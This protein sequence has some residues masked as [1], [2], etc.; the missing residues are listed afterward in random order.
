MLFVVVSCA[1]Q[2]KYIQYTVKRGETMKSIAQRLNMKTRDLLRL[3]PDVGRRPDPNT[4]II[5][6]QV[7]E[8]KKVD[9]EVAIVD[10]LPIETDLDTL[11]L[12]E[13]EVLTDEILRNYVIHK[14]KKGDTYYRLARIYNVKEQQIRDLNPDL[15]GNILPEGE[16]IKIKLIAPK[17]VEYLNYEDEIDPRASVRLAMLLPFRATAYDS[18]PA[19]DIFSTS[20][21]AN[22][23]T[24]LYL[25]ASLAI[26]SLKKQG[27]NINVD[28]FDTGSKNTK[29]DSLLDATNFNQYDAVIGPLYSDEIPKVVR[30]VKVPIVF[31]VYS[32]NQ[33]NFKN[34]RVI[35]TYPDVD[36]HQAALVDYMMDVHVNENVIIVGDSTAAS[37]RKSEQIR[38][39][40]LTHDSI[41][42]VKIL[43][44]E[45]GYIAKKRIINAL[46]RGVGNWI[47]LAVEDNVI[48]SDAI[49]SLISLP[50]EMIEESE[51]DRAIRQQKLDMQILPE[52]TYIRVFAF[53][54]SD[55]FDLVDNNKLARL[56]FTY[57]SDVLVD[58]TSPEV[59]IFN[60]QYFQRNN[61]LP[62]YYATKGFDITYDIGMRLASGDNLKATF[63]KGTSYRVESKFD[64]SR[65][66]FSTSYNSGIFIIQYN[67]DLTLTRLR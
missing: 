26:D 36:A 21:L 50:V 28:V 10:S 11:V 12:K 20:R 18:I 17:I 54:K 19:K 2:K 30:K 57:T 40:M 29:I 51:E 25:G 37:I 62:T 49:N 27:V 32:R 65:M 44:P 22:I 56:N 13:D 48:S 31:P 24:D 45:N 64:Y 58:E 41:S 34:S 39:A 35:K 1:Q 61:A 53:N 15:I 63:K 33:D 5:I 6:P 7:K 59:Q 38:R 16:E 3:N 47:V 4:V 42:H 9:K 66:L 23:T 55:K 43:H 67:P 8:Q 46:D 14:I 60:K 52:D